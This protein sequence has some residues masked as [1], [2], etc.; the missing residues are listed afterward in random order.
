MAKVPQLFPDGLPSS[1]TA[2]SLFSFSY[3]TSPFSFSVSRV[4]GDSMPLFNTSLSSDANDYGFN[5]FVFEDQYLEVTTNMLNS[6]TVYGLG[7]VQESFALP[8]DAHDYVM[9]TSDP[10]D[11]GVVDDVNLYGDYPLYVEQRASANGQVHGVFL[12]NSNAKRFSFAPEGSALSIKTIGGVLDL[13]FFLGPTVR[14]RY[15]VSYSLLGR[16]CCSSSYR[17][18]RQAYNAAILGSWLPPKRSWTVR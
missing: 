11:V 2:D 10:W 4:S 18:C 14:G 5:S 6:P 17:C 3:N 7:E 13:F 16:R 8:T 15:Y 12:A 1:T 9:W